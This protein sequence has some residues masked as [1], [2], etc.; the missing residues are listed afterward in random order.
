MLGFLVGIHGD[1]EK[2]I[3][4]VQD[5]ATNG[6]LNR[7]DAEIFLCALYRREN[8][9]QAGRAAGAGPDPP[10]SRATT[11]CAW[12][13]RRC[14]AWRATASA[15]L[16]AVEEVARLK[17]EPRPGLRPRAL[18][19]DLLPGRIHPILVQ[20]PGPVAGEPEEGGGGAGK[21]WT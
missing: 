18:G 4:T 6:K 17:T 9:T 7:V 10:L 20:R 8:Q 16:E 21:M 3:R 1:K 11:C 2:G 15:A 5:V 19:E 14:T 13:C 12:S